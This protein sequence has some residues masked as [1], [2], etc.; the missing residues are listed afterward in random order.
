[1]KWNI[2]KR[3]QNKV[4]P[5]FCRQK[6]MKL[7][8]LFLPTASRQ[9]FGKSLTKT[10]T[11][12]A[13]LPVALLVLAGC[14]APKKTTTVAFKPG[15]PGGTMLQTYQTTATVSAIDPVT[16]QVVFLAPDGSS[17]TF[18]AGPKIAIHQIKAG[19]AVKITV[20]RELIIYLDEREIP[21]APKVGDVVRSAP[22]VEPGVLTAAAVKLT[23]T[24]AAV[25]LPKREVTL[26]ISDGR[27]GTFK[28]RQDVDLT[29]V[30]LGTEVF[31]RTMTAAAILLEKP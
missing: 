1:M 20:A 24:V 30:K 5:T 16:R 9:H 15:V 22:G 6:S 2:L 7:T 27:T 13:L 21:P 29:G 25:D 12:L 31:I 4:L 10:M 26:N 23:A 28:L 3:L 19:D 8:A 17:N 14:T 11:S 18:T